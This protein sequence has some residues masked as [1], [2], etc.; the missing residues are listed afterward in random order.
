MQNTHCLR[1]AQLTAMA[2]LALS[3]CN[4]RHSRRCWCGRVRKHAM[5]SWFLQ[6]EEEQNVHTALAL[7]FWFVVVLQRVLFTMISNRRMTGIV[8]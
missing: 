7:W 5:A 1:S 3:L 8:S 2:L 6:S 4:E